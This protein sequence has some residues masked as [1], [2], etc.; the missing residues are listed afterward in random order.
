MS[1]EELIAIKELSADSIK[2]QLQALVG[3]PIQLEENLIELGIDSLHIMR[4]MN[5]WRSLGVSTTFS[6]LIENPTLKS[7]LPQLL[8]KSASSYESFSQLY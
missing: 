5:Q 6:Q 1:V 7:W 3:K 8:A 4:L 2:A